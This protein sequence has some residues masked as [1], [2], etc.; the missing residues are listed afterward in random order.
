MGRDL[1]IYRV[2]DG[3]QV[4]EIDC[5]RICGAIGR[6]NNHIVSEDWSKEELGAE[7]KYLID[8]LSEEDEDEDIG[9]AI[10]VYS[11]AL[12]NCCDCVRISYT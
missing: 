8:L 3:E 10:F 2:V 4:E 5:E 6:H 1:K 9:E 7:I 12:M 11:F